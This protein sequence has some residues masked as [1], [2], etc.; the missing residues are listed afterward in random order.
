MKEMIVLL[1]LSLSLLQINS[2]GLQVKGSKLYDG[3]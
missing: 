3:N 2:K 1:I